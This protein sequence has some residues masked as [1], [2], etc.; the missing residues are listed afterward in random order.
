MSV[1]Q[2][3]SRPVPPDQLTSLDCSVKVA[4]LRVSWIAP[5]FILRCSHTGIQMHWIRYDERDSYLVVLS[6]SALH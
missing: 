2:R 3:A 4:S 1:R 6:K 5:T